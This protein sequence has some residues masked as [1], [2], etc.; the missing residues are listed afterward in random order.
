[1]QNP[2]RLPFAMTCASLVLFALGLPRA[3]GVSLPVLKATLPASWD[4]SWFG[5]PAVWDLDGDGSNEIIAARHGTV[6]VWDADGALK[7]RAAAGSDGTLEEVHGNT[8]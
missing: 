8:R 7:W 6:Y 1:M 2:L 5:S 4:E 3:E